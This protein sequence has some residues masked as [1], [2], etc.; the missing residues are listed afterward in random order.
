MKVLDKDKNVNLSKYPEKVL[1]IKEP[2]EDQKRIALTEMPSL[3]SKLAAPSEADILTALRIDG[4]LIKYIR[5]RNKKMIDSALKQNGD[6]LQYIENPTECQI[7]MAIINSPFC[8][9]HIKSLTTSQQELAIR[10]DALT[11]QLMDN[12]SEHLQLLAIKTLP[13]VLGMLSSATRKVV[14]EALTLDGLCIEYVKEPDEELQLI[15]IANSSAGLAYRYIDTPSDSA[16]IA[17]YTKSKDILPFL[18]SVPEKLQEPLIKLD[19]KNIRY[20]K[21]PTKEVQQLLIKSLHEYPKIFDSIYN[22]DPEVLLGLLTEIAFKEKSDR[23][24]HIPEGLT[25]PQLKLYRFMQL[26]KRKIIPREDFTGLAWVDDRIHKL[27]RVEDS[28]YITQESLTSTKSFADTELCSFIKKNVKYAKMCVP[29]TNLEIL[30]TTCF[31][32]YVDAI[33]LLNLEFNKH[34]IVGISESL[35]DHTDPYIPNQFILGYVRYGT[36]KQNVLIDE[37]WI[38]SALKSNDEDLS[39]LPSWILSRFISEMW[40]YDF[41]KTYVLTKE[42]RTRLYGTNTSYPQLYTLLENSYFKR[43]LSKGFHPLVEGKE[44]F[45]LD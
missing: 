28:E 38:D 25:F 32:V 27:L 30:E 26:C 9:K 43:V 7:N 10:T 31:V 15:A 18:K 24:L 36:F 1:Q 3:I 37:L 17:A 2:T 12:P 14:I 33:K 35:A 29:T 8:I 21:N 45:I 40:H 5:N 34:H 23:L 11:I 42:L 4:L 20:I 13:S 19:P 22:I 44:L 6:A 41:H 16:A 39:W